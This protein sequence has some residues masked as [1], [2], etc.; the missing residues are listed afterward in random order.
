[1]DAD[2]LR[3]WLDGRV[4]AHEFSGAVLV[5]R[6]GKSLFS[7]A[8]GIAHRG[9]G[10]PVT[11]ST[12]FTVASVTKMVTA[13]TALRLVERGKVRLDQP[14][15][16][17]LP[18]E[19]QTAALTAAHTLHHLLSHTSGLPN[20][21]DDEAVT[22]D[23]FLSCWDR[24]PCQRARHPA[25]LLP[26]FRDLPAEAAPGERY[27][28][29]DANYILAGLV[30]EAVTGKPYGEAATG[31]VLTPADMDDS[32]FDLRDADPPRLATGYLHEEGR[33]FASWRANVFGGP[34]GGMPDGGLV[35]TTTDLA[36]LVDALTGGRL[37][38]PAT[39]AA[40]TSAQCGRTEGAER[41][42]YGLQLAFVGDQLVVLGHNG[43]DP[44]VSAVVTHHVAAATT[45]V[46][47]GN[48]DR[49]SWPV[50]LRLTA[51]LGLT[52]PRA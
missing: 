31:E 42:G 51:D 29:A 17:V 10:V 28:Y 19:Q 52:D 13:T 20:Y 33:P 49:G 7:Y 36:R 39:F 43:L 24:V 23:S 18:A 26:L 45:I 35:T 41:Y 38:S 34:A 5:W 9:H 46:V 3:D 4:A 15:T 37:V 32:G 21:H 40:M 16:E 2:L 8:G 11:G 22:W 27:S 25:D 30:I 44:G 12:R 1:M 47:L 50:Y 6:D 48:H 14:L